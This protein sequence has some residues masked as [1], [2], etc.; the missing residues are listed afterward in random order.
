MV[1][2]QVAGDGQHDEDGDDD[3]RKKL[4]SK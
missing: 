1:A 4:T 3:E 2:V